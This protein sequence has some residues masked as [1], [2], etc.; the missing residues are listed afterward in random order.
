[1]RKDYFDQYKDISAIAAISQMTMDDQLTFQFTYNLN[2][3]KP[4][5]VFELQF[6]RFNPH[7]NPLRKYEVAI[8]FLIGHD[9]KS[10]DVNM[11]NY[12]QIVNT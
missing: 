11:T 8:D 6:E 3:L 7:V 9:I 4:R 5:C 1:M 2:C 12:R 10:M